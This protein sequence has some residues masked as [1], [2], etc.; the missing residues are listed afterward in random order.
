M[1]RLLASTCLVAGFVLTA[2][3][4]QVGATPA[5]QG[6]CVSTRDNGGAAGARISAVA[7]PS[8]GPWVAGAIGGGVIGDDAGDPAC[9]R[10]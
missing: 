8:F 7:G 2:G 4:P 10:P 1:R 3:A 5:D 6:N 9:R